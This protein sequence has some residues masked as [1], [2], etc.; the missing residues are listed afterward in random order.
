MGDM[1]DFY[2]DMM[3]REYFESLD[4]QARYDAMT[5][6]EFVDAMAFWQEEVG[7]D[8]IASMLGF[9]RTRGYLTDKQRRY[10]ASIMAEV[11]VI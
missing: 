10:A 6:D 7:D 3:E 8:V 4:E 9:Y 5:L 2:D 1:A 11:A